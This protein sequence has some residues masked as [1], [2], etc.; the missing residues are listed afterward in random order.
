[1]AFVACVTLALGTGPAPRHV[2]EMV[3]A[4]SVSRVPATGCVP[5]GL[6]PEGLAYARIVCQQISRWVPRYVA[7]DPRPAVRSNENS[8]VRRYVPRLRRTAYKTRSRAVVRRGRSNHVVSRPA[9]AVARPRRQVEASRPVPAA[10]KERSHSAAP[11]PT[12]SP[13][14]QTTRPSSTVSNGPRAAAVARPARPSARLASH[15]RQR[16]AAQV[17]LALV[18][19]ALLGAGALVLVSGRISVVAWSGR[20]RRAG[21]RLPATGSDGEAVP[22]GDGVVRWVEGPPDPSEPI[23]GWSCAGPI[24]VDVASAGGVVGV[25]G[26]GVVRAALNAL[27]TRHRH[28]LVITADCARELYGE[29][30]VPEQLTVAATLDDAIG[31]VEAESVER[32]RAGE[33]GGLQ[34]DKR[35]IWLCARADDQ[36]IRLRSLFEGVRRYG[37]HAVLLGY[38]PYGL[39]LTVDDDGRVLS[40]PPEAEPLTGSY[41][42]TLSP[43]TVSRRPP[44][45]ER[46]ASSPV[47]VHE[48][49]GEPE[50]GHRRPRL[51]ILGPAA[52]SVDGVEMPELLERRFSWEVATYL[53]CHPDG[54]TSD[55]I[56]ED[57]WPSEPILSARK[58]FTDAVYHLRKALRTAAGES[59]AKFVLLRMNRYRL[60]EQLLDVD[61]WEFEAAVVNGRSASDDGERLTSL[62]L[63]A[64]LYR[65][66]LAHVG[67]GLWA[68]PFLHD[69]RRKVM[70]AL[71]G[72]ASLLED[73]RPEKAIAML[74]EISKMMPWAEEADRRIMRI[75]ERLH[76]TE[77]MKVAYEALKERLARLGEQPSAETQELVSALTSDGTA[78]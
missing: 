44:L 58:R 20:L 6:P 78:I 54:V 43:G 55:A 52:I 63:A 18:V 32:I 26:A 14:P 51:L 39:S 5:A 75:H 47:Q 56:I 50:D 17:P 25:C 36:Q 11:R 69:I 38:W 72:A 66:E 24:V 45:D 71:E 62:Q 59:G 65:G 12:P 67:D 16:N 22:A 19:L 8:V 4:A 41:L 73:R 21:P 27:T 70:G 1:M 68:E 31:L 28:S 33:N 2:D 77:D 40:A 48:M 10:G 23:Q 64:E 61:L 46:E 9:R 76:R 57:L 13:T 37:V 49:S 29:G 7:A 53:A 60:D 35:Q 34:D 42:T 74:E 3:P 15:G 30:D